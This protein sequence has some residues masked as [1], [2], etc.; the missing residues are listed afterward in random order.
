MD[1][2]MVHGIGRQLSTVQ[3]VLKHLE[4]KVDELRARIETIEEVLMRGQAKK[5]RPN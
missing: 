5:L 1:E 4:A 3:N 2:R